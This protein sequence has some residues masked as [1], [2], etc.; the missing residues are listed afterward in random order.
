MVEI[1]ISKQVSK[2]LSRFDQKL[3]S[4]PSYEQTL[5]IVGKESEFLRP[6]KNFPNDYLFRSTT[7]DISKEESRSTINLKELY[8]QSLAKYTKQPSPRSL[9]PDIVP[10]QK[11]ERC[12]T[13]NHDKNYT[14]IV[15]KNSNFQPKL[16]KNSLKI[17][18]KLG[19]AKDRLTTSTTHKN[20]AADE[21]F[22]YKPQINSKSKIIANTTK[23][24]GK[25]R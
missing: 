20:L 4:S 3:I 12:T 11:E 5:K 21:H 17:A 13:P 22:T 2:I 25:Q 6:K 10:I 24:D 15:K 7:P 19:D 18:A 14:Q 16:N 8:N 1:S 9:T 23:I